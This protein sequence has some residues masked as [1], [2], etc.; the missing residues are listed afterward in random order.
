MC[1]VVSGTLVLSLAAGFLLPR[2]ARLDGRTATLGILPGAASGMLAMSAPLGADP[3]LVAL[4]QYTRV[5]VVVLSSAVVSR[6]WL[7]S[8]ATENAPS[9]HSLQQAVPSTEIVFQGVWVTYALTVLIAALGAWAGTRLR[10][11]AG[12]LL[13]PLILGIVLEQLGILHLAWPP[14]VPQIAYL[15]LGLYVGLLFDRDSARGAVHMLP[16]MLVSTMVLVLSCAGLG[17]MLT[18]FSNI[19]GL[20]AYLATTPGGIDSVA[21]MA[22]GS[23]ADAPLVLAIQMLR[24]IAV[25]LVAAILGR[26]WQ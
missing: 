24:L 10:L 14:G 12:G 18:A 15:V 13:G 5:V 9:E 25:V 4:M 20:T 1:L 6:L 23:G 19:D 26:W 21:I 17:W 22:L 11:P 8:E 7:T 16:V 2:F 3:R